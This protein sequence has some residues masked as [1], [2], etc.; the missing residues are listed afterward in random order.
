MV[1]GINTT[2]SQKTSF[3]DFKK[4]NQVVVTPIINTSPIPQDAVLIHNNAYNPAPPMNKLQMAAIIAGG[5]TSIAFLVLILKSLIPSRKAQLFIKSVINDIKNG[6][7]PQHVKDKLMLETKKLNTSD[8]DGAMNYINNVKRLPYKIT[9]PK[10]ININEAKKILDEKL[11]GLDEV[12]EEIVSYLKNEQYYLEN[13]IDN[14]QRKLLCLVGPPGVAKTSSAK[15]IAEVMGKP[16]ERITLGGESQA[17][18][19]KG[20]ERVFKNSSPGQIIKSMQDAKVT[21]PVILLDEI[22]KMGHNTEH[23]ASAPALLDVLEPEQCKNFTDK[24]L[25]FSYDLSNVN[26]ILTANDVNNIPKALKDRL[27]IIDIKPYTQETKTAICNKKRA[28]II[29]NLKLDESKIDFQPE[30]TS[31]IVNRAN[32]EGARKTI[33]NLERVFEQIVS[34]IQTNGKDK[35]ITI[36][37]G[38]VDNALKNIK[39]E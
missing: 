8:A 20:T 39:K 19:I 16:F 18:F 34:D 36:H 6:D 31:E 13:G 14:R 2:D 17:T 25:E 30:A 7:M 11:V 23:G 4:R 29:K 33:D 21:D 38:Y 5:L 10:K 1:A 27:R 28:E 26:F 9:E 15:I 12:K 24:F 35:K 3:N 22:D 32:D 37:S